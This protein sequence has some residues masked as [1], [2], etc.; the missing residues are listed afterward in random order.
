MEFIQI[1]ASGCAG[2]IG[3]KKIHR[4]SVKEEF[5]VRDCSSCAA[6][7]ECL[8]TEA[9][10]QREWSVESTAVSAPIKLPFFLIRAVAGPHA[11]VAHCKIPGREIALAPRPIQE[12]RR[13]LPGETGRD[14]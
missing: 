11:D 1:A 2:L 6:H 8:N 5:A 4:N 7:P 9:T 14:P 10:N 12:I 3:I 13:R